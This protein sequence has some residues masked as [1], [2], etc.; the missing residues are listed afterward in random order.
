ML[1]CGFHAPRAHGVGRYFDAVASLVL[2]RAAVTFEGQAALEWNA[3]ADPAEKGA[4]AYDLD[5]RHVTWEVDLRDM[6]RAIVRDVLGGV[7]ARVI[8][9]RFHNTLAAATVAMVRAA[10]ASHGVRPVVLT[11]GCFQNERLAEEVLAR[12][13]GYDVRLPR[14]VPPGDGGLALGQVLVADA[15]VRRGA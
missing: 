8:S 14:R 4:Y 3:I 1:R 9:A 10:A 6:T 12:L 5:R 2:G 11:G 15:L 7:S 13:G